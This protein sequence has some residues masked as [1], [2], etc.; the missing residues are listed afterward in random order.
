VDLAHG[1]TPDANGCR[2]IK[3]ID[4]DTLVL[5]CENF[6]V[7]R[8]RLAGF[9]T[10]EIFT[11][12]C[13]GEWQAGQ[14]ATW[15]LRRLLWSA[16]LVEYRVRGTDKYGRKLVA[17]QVDGRPLSDLMVAAGH[18]RAYDGGRRYGWCA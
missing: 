2:L 14:A 1:V 10:P 17:V 8:A 16:G 13:L 7:F 5:A 18:A 15:Y 3:V 11:P 12:G 9:D 6:G 4:G